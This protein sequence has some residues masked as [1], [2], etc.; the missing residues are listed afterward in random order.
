MQTKIPVPLSCSP[1]SVNSI[2]SDTP[3][4][5]QRQLT[6]LCQQ[7]LRE[8]LHGLLATVKAVQ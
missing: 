4:I 5:Q 1:M 7:L 6:P 2:G 3:T 8:A